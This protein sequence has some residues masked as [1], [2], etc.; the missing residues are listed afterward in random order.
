MCL[1][2]TGGLCR[3]VVTKAGLNVVHE[4]NIAPL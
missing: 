2:Y 1:L 3:P 4:I